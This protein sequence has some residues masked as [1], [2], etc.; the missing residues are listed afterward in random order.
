MKPKLSIYQHLT[1]AKEMLKQ[2]YDLEAIEMRLKE[3]GLGQNAIIEIL[4]FFA[5]S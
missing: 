2:G 1:N 3:Q 4:Q 5:T